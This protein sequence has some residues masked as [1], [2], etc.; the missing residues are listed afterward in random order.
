MRAILPAL[1]AMA[2]AA[3]LLGSCTPVTP[4]WDARFGE[5]V[6]MAVAAQT[7]H[8]DA[9]RNQDP[10]AGIDGNP[11][12]DGTTSGGGAPGL[13][14]YDPGWGATTGDGTAGDGAGGGYAIRKNG[15]S[16]PVSNSGAIYGA[17]S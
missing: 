1:L 15:H 12:S 7:L 3:G 2:G 8:P 5:T 14:F 10:V 4:N 17:A 9:D 16:V 6:N 11:G 13:G